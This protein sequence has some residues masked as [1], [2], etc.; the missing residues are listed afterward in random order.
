LLGFDVYSIYA[1]SLAPCSARS[2]SRR[3]SRCLLE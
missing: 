2:S 3:G 1:F